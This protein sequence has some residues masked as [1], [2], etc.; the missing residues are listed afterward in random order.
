[1]CVKRGFDTGDTG[2]FLGLRPYAVDVPEDLRKR[3]EKVYEMVRTIKSRRVRRRST[4]FRGS[5]YDL[6]GS[7]ADHERALTVIDELKCLLERR[8]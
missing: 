8:D 7:K 5:H 3:V 2:S 1:M 6:S 4:S